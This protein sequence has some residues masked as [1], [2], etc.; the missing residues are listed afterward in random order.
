YQPAKRGAARAASPSPGGTTPTRPTPAAKP[1]YGTGP[2]FGTK[3]GFGTKPT[4]APKPPLGGKVAGGAKPV[5]GGKGPPGP[6]ARGTGTPPPTDW[7]AV[8]DWYDKL[9]GDEGSEYHQK[10]IF[11]GVLRLLAPKP[12]DP[13]LD[14]ACGQGALARLL[15]AKG[16]VVTGVD[17]AEPL[18]RAAVARGPADASYHVGD[19]RKLDEVPG[20]AAGTFAAAACVLAIQNIN[21]I[22]PVFAGVAAALRPMGRLVLVMMHPCFRG[23]KETSWGW[24]EQTGSQY[25][26]VDR[27]LMPR[28]EPIITH[29]GSDPLGYTWTFHKPIEQYVKALRG[30]GLLVDAI[31][32]W[33]SHKV[34]QPGPRATV[35]NLARE[36]I[37]MFM[38]IRAVKV[39]GAAGE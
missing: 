27:Y 22:G 32:E 16:A 23:P 2:T 18:V 13:I 26:R 37:P 12:G 34:S 36:E 38:A 10:V 5:A 20:V 28:K 30:A 33:A 11:P 31:E 4:F 24:D 3:P 9:V 39:G 14:V 21:P 17:A 8:A 7:A 25:R 1:A 19:A 15:A 6:A 29:P 35:E